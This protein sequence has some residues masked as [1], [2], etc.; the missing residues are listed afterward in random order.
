VLGGFWFI[1]G[2]RV[3]DTTGTPEAQRKL[4][5]VAMPLDTVRVIYRERLRAMGWTLVSDVGDS[6][7]VAM[8]A[9]RDSSLVWLTLARGGSSLTTYTVIG[10]RAGSPPQP[11]RSP[12]RP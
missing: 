10:A 3:R 4:L 12:A 11:P 1:P 7:Q 9:R 8:H 2:S 5:T 6:S